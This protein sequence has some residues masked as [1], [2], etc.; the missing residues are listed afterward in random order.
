MDTVAQVVTA[1]EQL[2]A[3][4]AAAAWSAG[5]EQRPTQTKLSGEAFVLTLVGGF[6]RDPQA[7]RS[8]LA[9]TAGQLGVAISP[10]GLDQRLAAPGARLLQAVLRTATRATVARAEP[11]ALPLLE[12]FA[13]VYAQ[14]STVIALPDALG[15][16][17]PGCGG[18]TAQ[19]T[20]A[21]VKAQLRLELRGGQLAG[22]ELQ[23]G[24]AHDQSGALV[25]DLGVPGSLHLRDLGYFSL[26]RLA[27]LSAA[28]RYWLTRAKAGVHVTL[29]DGTAQVTAAWLRAQ[30]PALQDVAV[31]VGQRGPLAARL[32]AAPVPPA[33][34]Q[35][36]R[37]K[38]RAEAQREGHTPSRARLSLADWTVVLTNVPPAL[39]TGAEA[40][41]L[42][43]VRWQIEL[44]FKLWKQNRRLA[45][46]QSTRPQAILC[47]LYAKLLGLVV[48]HWLILVGTGPPP[49]RSLAKAARIVAL[50]AGLLLAAWRG[51]LPLALAVTLVADGID[52]GCRLERRRQY[53]SA[54]QLLADP[55]LPVPFRPRYAKPR[56]RKRVPALRNIA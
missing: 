8:V 34:A 56:G 6:L 24:R 41:V 37:R 16:E 4:A 40:L 25:D 48:Q 11:S 1:L 45:Q 23:A 36:R 14:D 31:T 30:G 42:L 12:R 9:A 13:A 50:N 49:R 53:P 2:G 10:Q 38:L 33:V 28:D 47:E 43:G 3:T 19:G 7:S 54:A 17:W 29:A 46:W 5:Y 44:V 35:E 21:A 15:P 26:D 27:A 52:T 32:I 51:R 20:Q 39:L 18:R 55:T 22:P